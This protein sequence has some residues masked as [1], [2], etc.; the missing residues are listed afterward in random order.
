MNYAQAIDVAIDAI[1]LGPNADRP[2]GERSEDFVAINTLRDLQRFLNNNP[3][4]QTSKPVRTCRRCH[5][6]GEG[7]EGA[8]CLMCSGTGR[9]QDLFETADTGGTS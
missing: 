3:D 7:H 8:D 9:L 6:T 2:V 1:V 4:G 5:G